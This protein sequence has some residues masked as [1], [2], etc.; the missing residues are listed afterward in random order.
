M[1]DEKFTSR[2]RVQVLLDK[3]KKH[4]EHLLTLEK[5]S[6]TIL[7]TERLLKVT[8]IEKL[9]EEKTDKEL[10]KVWAQAINEQ[11]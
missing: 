3:L 9:L 2:V 6:V 4:N 7:A 1:N 11:K 10:D 5:D 8:V